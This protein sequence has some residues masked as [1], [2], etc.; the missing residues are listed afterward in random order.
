[1]PISY[2]SS[3]PSET[4]PNPF[5]TTNPPPSHLHED[6]PTLIMLCR[7]ALFIIYHRRTW[8]DI[9]LTHVHKHAW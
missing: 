7:P 9:A 8:K 5:C 3:P 1:M 2:I 4:H 6:A